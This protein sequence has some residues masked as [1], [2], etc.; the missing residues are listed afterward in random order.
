MKH[1]KIQDAKTGAIGDWSFWG[2]KNLRLIDAH[3]GDAT[4]VIVNPSAYNIPRG[5]KKLCRCF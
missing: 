4:R 3:A 1:G 5:L 2:I